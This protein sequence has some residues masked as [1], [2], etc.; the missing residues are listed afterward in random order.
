MKH[1]TFTLFILLHTL[2]F[3]Q[4]LNEKSKNIIVK[5]L[6]NILQDDQKNRMFL[7]LGTLDLKK[8]DSI[9]KLPFEQFANL[10]NLLK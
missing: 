5:Q 2:I 7:T 9:K 6:N 3:G 4:K 10:N 8:I 1:I